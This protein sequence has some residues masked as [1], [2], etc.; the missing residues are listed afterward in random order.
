MYFQNYSR[1]ALSLKVMV[2][3]LWMCDTAH[4]A[5]ITHDTY[6]HGITNFSN[7]A[8]LEIPT[9][10][11]MISVIITAISDLIVRYI[12]GRRLWKLSGGNIPLAIS[13]A[14]I[15]LLGFGSSLGFTSLGIIYNTYLKFFKISYLLYLAFGSAVVADAIIASALCIVL[16]KSRTGFRRTDSLVNILLVYTINTG[17]LTGIVAMLCFILYAVMPDTYIFLAIY[18]NL[19]KLY[20]NALLATLNARSNLQDQMNGAISTIPLPGIAESG[21]DNSSKRIPTSPHIAINVERYT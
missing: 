6:F 7:P 11:I 17:L 14:V 4:L 15:S 16:A 21:S 13:I 18:L 19:S 8:A 2:F 9:L 10:S 12:F 1:D 3:F 5:L 20:L